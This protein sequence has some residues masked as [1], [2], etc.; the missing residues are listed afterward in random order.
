VSSRLGLRADW[1]K[2]F[3][4]E[5]A[6]THLGG[7]NYNLLADRSNLSLMAGTAF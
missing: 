1:G 2:R 5:A 3:F 7:N 4:A 6:Y